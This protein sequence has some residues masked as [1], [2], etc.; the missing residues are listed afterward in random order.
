MVEVK[1][2]ILPDPLIDKLGF[3]EKTV[4][5]EP[6]AYKFDELVKI[7]IE[8]IE[9]LGE[10]LSTK[11]LNKEIFIVVDNRLSYDPNQQIYIK[12]GSKIAIF[13][14]GAGG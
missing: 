2:R 3:Q 6:G 11:T 7:L 13:T 4:S 12:E 8:N 1:I 10:V 9:G 14:V 5:I